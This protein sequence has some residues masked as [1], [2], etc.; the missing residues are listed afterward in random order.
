MA[1]EP[2][3]LDRRD[4]ML[5]AAAGA[6]SLAAST[7]PA[8]AQTAPAQADGKGTIFSGDV[9]DGKKVIQALDIGDLDPGRHHFYFEGVQRVSGQHW[10]VS[11][12]VVKGE[13]PGK[14]VALV[15]GVHGD[16]ISPIRTIQAVLEQLDPAALSGSVL[17]VLDVSSPALEGMA[18]RWPNSDRGIDLID[19][20]REWPG[21]ENGPN[22]A[23]RQAWLLFNKLMK[24]N[25]DYAIDFHTATTGMDMTAFHLA[26]MDLPEV[27]AMAE[28]YPID[29]IFDDVAYPT[30]LANAFIDAG[31]PAFTPEIGA[32]RALDRPMIELFVEGTMNVLKLHGLIE[33]AMGK[34]GKDSD[35]FVANGMGAV[36]ASHG[37]YVELLVELND[38]VEVGQK[39]AVQRNAFGETVVEYASPVAGEVAARRTDATAEPGSPLIFFLIKSATPVEDEDYPE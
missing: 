9:I 18:R 10:Y 21:S 17:A 35:I 5:L 37:G 26:R 23:S 14:R 29:Q 19:I 11:V 8:S 36:I 24:P 4:F 30:L 2:H 38:K 15:S 16:E 7:I 1:N 27:K 20:N 3:G 34:T 32:P 39:V 13:K 22:A 6:T 31:I 33:G 28:L 12:V 25:A